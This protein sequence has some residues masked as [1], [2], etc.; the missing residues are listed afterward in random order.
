V[1]RR[2]IVVGVTPNAALL[3][4]LETVYRITYYYSYTRIGSLYIYSS[5][6]STRASLILASRSVIR[7]T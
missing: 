3:I 7:R 1:P 4:L 5:S 6:S 2:G